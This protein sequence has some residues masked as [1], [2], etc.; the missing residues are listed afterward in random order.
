MP[1]LKRGRSR[2]S[3]RKGDSKNHGKKSIDKHSAVNI[4]I[5]QECEP[6]A[7][8]D[9][10]IVTASEVII[11]K[12]AFQIFEY[13]YASDNFFRQ[14]LTTLKSD[15]SE[16]VTEADEGSL[17]YADE[18]YVIINKHAFQ[19]YEHDDLDL[20]VQSRKARL[21]S[22]FK[23]DCSYIDNDDYVC[24]KKSNSV[25]FVQMYDSDD[26]MKLKLA[27]SVNEDFSVSIQVHDKKLPSNHE[28]WS[29]IPRICTTTFT[30]SR[31]LREVGRFNICSGNPD[32]DLQ[33]FIPEGSYL[34][35]RDGP[36]RQ[37]LRTCYTG[38]ST[39][40]STNCQL[41]VQSKR[42]KCCQIYR[43]T[44][45]TL[46]S[47]QEKTPKVDTPKKDWLHCQT[48]FN[49]LTP[50]QKFYKFKQHQEY[51]KTLEQEN[52][53]LKRQIKNEIDKNGVKLSEDESMDFMELLE[54]SIDQGCPSSESLIDNV[55]SHSEE[56]SPVRRLTQFSDAGSWRSQ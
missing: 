48:P 18:Y 44:L 10:E 49:K 26:L 35:A 20:F 21:F 23:E 19:Y 24:H 1:V 33:T 4:E 38:T 29:S 11:D 15:T 39:I 32:P 50:N 41:L 55:H 5:S 34:D 16:T 9:S 42:C 2:L 31:I 25:R 22:K 54:N 45:R 28:I 37:G 8:C 43:R 12:K 52:E 56:H 7:M 27:V 13:T 51:T 46:L 3:S 40:I 6:E 30:M 47:R 53:K 36:S 17:D 14:C